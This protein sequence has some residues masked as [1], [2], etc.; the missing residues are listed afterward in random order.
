MSS[1]CNLIGILIFNR[2]TFVCP[3]FCLMFVALF[4]KNDTLRLLCCH[5]YKF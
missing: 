3:C 2:E 5:D 4:E 1:R